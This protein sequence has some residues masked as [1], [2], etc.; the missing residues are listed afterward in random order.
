MATAYALAAPRSLLKIAIVGHVD[1][2]KSTLVGRLLNDTNSLPAGKID[3]VAEMCKRRG[4]PFEWAF[5]TDALR[6]ERDQGITIDASHIRFSDAVRDY[7]LIDA[8][9]HREFLKNMISG[10][11]GCDAALVVIDADEVKAAHGATVG[12]LDANALF[13]LRSRGL[14]Q[15]QAQALL[16]AAFCHEP[17]KILPEALREQLARRLDKALVEAGVA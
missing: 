12:Q 5:V 16:S 13:Y 14:P 8:P 17:L 11:A 2:G 1:H 7:V 15:A 6:A 3:S 10:A 9:G 4:M